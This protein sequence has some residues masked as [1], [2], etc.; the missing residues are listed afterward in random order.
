MGKYIIILMTFALLGGGVY[1]LS[2]STTESLSDMKNTGTD[3]QKSGEKREENPMY[4]KPPDMTID[5]TKTY[6]AIMTTDKGRMR[7]VLDAKETPVT[8]NNFVFL[9]RDGYYDGTVFHRIMKDF[10]VQGG[11]PTG[12]GTGSPGYRFNDEPITKE[13]I[14]GTLAMANSGP[15]T[16]GSQFFIMHKDYQL[17]KSYVIFGAIDPNDTESLKT[18][19]ALASTDVQDNGRGEMSRPQVPVILRSIS[20]EES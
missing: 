2:S 20:I 7:V 10:M 15:N 14:R 19:D 1:M 12:S 4:S 16:N 9:A 8:V 5:S 13:Y 3:P 18:L 11:D 17:E 6:T